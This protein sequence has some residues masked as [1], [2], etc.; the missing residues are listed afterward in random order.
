MN[1]QSQRHVK[2]FISFLLTAFLASSAVP[3]FAQKEKKKFKKG[4]DIQLKDSMVV[5]SQS[6]IFNFPNVNRIKEYNDPGKLKKIHQLDVSKQD[7]GLYKALREYVS[8]FGI[9]NFSRNT[10]MIWK[11]AQLSRKFGQPGEAILLYKLALKH[12]TQGINIDDIYAQYDSIEP[13]KKKYYV[14]LKDYYELVNYRKEI[15]TL[16]PP[17]SVLEPMGDYINSPKEDYGPTIGNVDDVLLFTSKRNKN[18]EGKKQGD[19]DRDQ[20]P[21]QNMSSFLILFK[22]K[23]RNAQHI[24]VSTSQGIGSKGIM[25]QF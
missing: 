14:P 3:G 6:D 23:Y 11:L 22:V 24:P 8:N 17:Q 5:Y 16:R 9:D 2:I 7:E 1:R 21:D 15:D 20:Q 12:Y 18:R 25:Q 19:N 10:P 4:D 13:D